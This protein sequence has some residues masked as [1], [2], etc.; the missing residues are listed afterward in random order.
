VTKHRFAPMFLRLEVSGMF[1]RTAVVRSSGAARVELSHWLAHGGCIPPAPF[2]WR[3]D[4]E[5]PEPPD[6]PCHA[7]SRGRISMRCALF[8]FPPTLAGGKH[9]LSTSERLQP[10]ACLRQRPAPAQDAFYR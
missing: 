4:T 3:G 8:V 9:S 10:A 5:K 7:E 2:G 1:S 6:V